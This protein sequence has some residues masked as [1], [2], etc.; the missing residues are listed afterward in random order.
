MKKIFLFISIF[1]VIYCNS[2]TEKTK[3]MKKMDGYLNMYW[4]NSSG[5][6][7]LEISD[8]D[9]EF[10]YVNSLMAGMGSNDVGLD[11]GQLGNSRIVY[12]HRV[13]PK[14]LLIQPNYRYRANTN[15]AKEKASVADGFAKS[16]IWGF[17]AAEEENGKVLVDATDFFLNDAHGIVGRLKRQKMGNYKV[18]KSRSAIHLPATMNFPNNT[19]VEA[20]MTYTGTN[21]GSFV[22]QVTPTPSAITMRIHHS[23]LELP[24]NNY[25]PRKHDPRAGYGAI[26]FQDY[27]VPLDE[28][29]F[30]KYIR[31]HRL[32]KKN[33]N[34]RRSE[35]KEPIIYYVDPGVPE[36]VKT[37]MLESGRWWNQCISS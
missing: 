9:K 2:I 29:I 21:P 13:G 25:Q 17:K 6:L 26:S 14:I 19:E 18:D 27:A 3:S 20:L 28:S 15:D 34:S 8:F 30:I 11:R 23:F 22:R 10:L 5:K 24:D 31:R 32:E 1:G 16:T 33:P 35:A 36:P 37:A 12:F 7:W 4:D